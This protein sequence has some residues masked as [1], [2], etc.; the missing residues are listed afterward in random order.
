MG[1][2]TYVVFWT[3]ALPLGM[4]AGTTGAH[5]H[6]RI[7]ERAHKGRFTPTVAVNPRQ[8]AILPKESEQLP[9]TNTF[10]YTLNYPI[11]FGRPAPSGSDTTLHGKLAEADK[12]PLGARGGKGIAFGT[13]AMAFP[14]GTSQSQHA[15]QEGP[16]I[17]SGRS[18]EDVTERCDLSRGPSKGAVHEQAVSGTEERWDFQASDKLKRSEQV[19]DKEPLQDGGLS[20][21]EGC[22]TERRLDVINRPQ[23]CLLLRPNSL[24]SSEAA[25]V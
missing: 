2:K 24:A 17:S 16:G 14:A 7:K 9:Y 15:E 21:A 12:R 25:P 10:G 8:P 20:Y 11:W 18:R 1:K 5:N 19:R 3:K 4:G 6:A 13:G 22:F 23:G